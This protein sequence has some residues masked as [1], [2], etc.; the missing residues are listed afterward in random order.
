MKTVLITGASSGFGEAAAYEFASDKKHRLILM[1]RRLDRLQQIQQAL[2][3]TEIHIAEV[4]VTSEEQVTEFLSALPK[5]FQTI[6]VLVNSAGLALGLAPAHEA[7]FS[8]W[9]TMVN[10]NIMGLIRMTRKVLPQMVARNAGQVINIGSIAGA[11]PYPGANVYG[12]SKAFVQQFSRELRADVL[13]KAIRITNIDPGLA[14]TEF[15]NVRFKGDDRKADSVYEGTQPL[16]AQDVAQAIHW[17]T[18]V[19]DHVNINAMEIMP[20]CQSWAP[21]AIQREDD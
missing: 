20:T 9:E 18:S 4:D 17:V 14:E 6:D 12:A 13:G 15:S 7:D 21:L 11:W 5:P 2:P 10:T 1:A 8:D 16:R 3:D 19:P